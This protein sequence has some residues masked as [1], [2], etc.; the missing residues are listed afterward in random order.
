MSR[1]S[2]I[3]FEK[4]AI[5]QFRREYKR[6]DYTQEELEDIKKSLEARDPDS[7]AKAK[8]NELRLKALNDLI[9]NG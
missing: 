7:P 8:E 5:D 1:S 6:K 2:Q 9:D 4:M 3:T